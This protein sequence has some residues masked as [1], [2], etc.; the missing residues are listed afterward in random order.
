MYVTRFKANFVTSVNC[1]V[2]KMTTFTVIKSF[3]HKYEPI[4]I[5]SY[6]NYFFCIVF[7]NCNSFFA[8][9]SD[10]I[11]CMLHYDPDEI[12]QCQLDGA[13]FNITST[14]PNAS[15]TSPEN[16]STLQNNKTTESQGGSSTSQNITSTS[17]EQST[18]LNSKTT[19][20]TSSE[21]TESEHDIQTSEGSTDMTANLPNG[22]ILL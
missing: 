1:H 20:I 7:P 4:F 11:Q 22:V 15:T 6:I 8:E 5:L 18:P 2:A 13:I 17:P 19:P 14:S 10:G 9:L 12:L 16:S 21:I 3:L